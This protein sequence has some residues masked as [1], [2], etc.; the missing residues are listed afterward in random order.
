MKNILRF[1]AFILILLTL[2]PVALAAKATPN[3]PPI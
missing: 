3:P 1:T 2:A